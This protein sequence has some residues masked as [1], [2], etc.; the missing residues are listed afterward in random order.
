MEKI[1]KKQLVKSARARRVRAK[2]SGNEACPRVAVNKT[3]KH[4]SAQAIDDTKGITLASIT[5]KVFE[6]KNTGIALAS[7]LGES[8]GAKLKEAG[9]KEIVFDRKS[10]KY[11]GRVSAFA[12]GIRK[13]GIK[14]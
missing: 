11:H 10:N 7:E 3:A 9:V 8:F 2:I 12:D 5:S 13:A 6:S 1:I 4:F 14:F